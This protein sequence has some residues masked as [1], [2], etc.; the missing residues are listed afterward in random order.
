MPPPKNEGPV[1]H[2]T[3]EAGEHV[4]LPPQGGYLK[5]PTKDNARE[6][7]KASR[8]ALKMNRRAQVAEDAEHAAEV[9]KQALTSIGIAGDEQAVHATVDGIVKASDMMV[10]GYLAVLASGDPQFAPQHGKE[11]AD[12]MKAVSA[13]GKEYRTRQQLD[14]LHAEITGKPSIE[15]NVTAKITELVTRLEKRRDGA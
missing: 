10:A 12:M 8:V 3:N 1:V 11:A 6:R 9:W 15:G 13:I 4:V 14:R 2:T 7:Q 5:P